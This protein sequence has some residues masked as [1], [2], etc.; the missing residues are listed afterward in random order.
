MKKIHLIILVVLCSSSAF[1]QTG[2]SYL[3]M[4]FNL[5]SENNNRSYY[6]SVRNRFSN[7]DVFPIGIQWI[8]Y[9]NEHSAMRYGF[10]LFSKRLF[11]NFSYSTIGDTSVYK[12]NA[13]ELL[14]PKFTVGK[15]WQKHIHKDIE[16]YGGLDLGFGMMKNPKMN[17]EERYTSSSFMGYSA[18]QTASVLAFNLSA[19]PFMGTRISWNRFVVGYEASL[20]VNYSQVIGEDIRNTSGLKLQHQLNFG[21]KLHSKKK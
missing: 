11:S 3:M 19:R 14:M 8:K 1:A 4:N 18:G 2:S 6:P 16:V 17:I 7:K 21:Y 12:G 9:K 10:T 13:Y 20:P 5:N 15:E